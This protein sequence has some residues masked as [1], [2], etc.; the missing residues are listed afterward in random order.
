MRDDNPV[1]MPGA[2]YT[3]E[4]LLRILRIGAK[5]LGRW[6]MAGLQARRPATKETFYFADDVMEIMR[7][8]SE[9][10]PKYV[11]KHRRK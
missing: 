11:A 4:Q 1:L 2:V 7:L 10:F 9:Q 6:E 3:R 5:T 8:P